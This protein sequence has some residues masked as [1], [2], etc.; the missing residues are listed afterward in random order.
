MFNLSSSIPRR[1]TNEKREEVFAP[2]L[3]PSLQG[4]VFFRATSLSTIGTSQEK[5]R[6]CKKGDRNPIEMVIFIW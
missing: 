1:N 5:I 4:P 2:W 6:K 3:G